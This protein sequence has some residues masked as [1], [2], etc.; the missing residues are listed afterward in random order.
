MLLYYC[1]Y[2][3]LSGKYAVSMTNKAVS[4]TAMI[5]G[6]SATVFMNRNNGT[7]TPYYRPWT[8]CNPAITEKVHLNIHK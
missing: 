1:Y 3:K 8:V 4:M 2:V 5:Q 7:F 6:N